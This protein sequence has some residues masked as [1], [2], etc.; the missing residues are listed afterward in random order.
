MKEKNSFATLWRYITGRKVVENAMA[1]AG[2]E[3]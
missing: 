2:G 1:P 3:I